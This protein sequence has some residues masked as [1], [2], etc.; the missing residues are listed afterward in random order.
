MTSVHEKLVGKK[1]PWKGYT[2]EHEVYFADCQNYKVVELELPPI[3]SSFPE[4][5]PV[6]FVVELKPQSNQNEVVN[7]LPH[8][9]RNHCVV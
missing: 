8:T 2:K 4:T 7:F 3:D 5:E 6:F 1:V 9:K